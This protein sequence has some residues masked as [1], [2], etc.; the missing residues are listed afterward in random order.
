[1]TQLRNLTILFFLFSWQ[2]QANVVGIDAQNFNPTSNGLD[3]VTVQSS[4]TL[5]PGIFNLGL[6]FNYATNTL[7]NYENTVT[8][9]RDEPQDQLVSM[10]VS[11][12]LGLTKNWD[13][14]FTVPQLLWQD[15]DESTTVF[16]GQFENTGVTE[17]RFNTKYRFF[18]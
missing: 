5:E 16:R 11:I 15:V 9:T 6:F 8:Q 7:P 13:V 18:W 1:M 17:Y 2:A 10:D 12:G 3:F 14:G 4:E